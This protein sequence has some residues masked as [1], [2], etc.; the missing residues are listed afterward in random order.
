MLSSEYP[1]HFIEELYNAE[2]EKMFRFAYHILNILNNTESAKDMVQETFL[3]ALFHQEDLIAH[4]KPEGWLMLTLRNLVL[5]ELRR[6]RVTAEVPIES[7]VELGQEDQILPV[8]SLLPKQLSESER[9][10]L[11]W[12]YRDKMEY[13]EIAAA[14]GITESS[15]R[16]R[17]SRTIGHCKKL[18][19]DS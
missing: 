3:L 16:S 9:T 17:I 8:E 7:I 18:L 13:S 14:L 6:K 12:R 10:I 15:C 2:Y 19:K 1:K 11:L 4:P 5:N